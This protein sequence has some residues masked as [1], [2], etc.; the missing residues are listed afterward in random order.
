MN[1][2]ANETFKTPNYAMRRAVAL[3]A[4]ALAVFGGK[5]LYT[6]HQENA[7]IE[8]IERSGEDA[9]V[10]YNSG[11]FNEDKVTTVKIE[12]AQNAFNV[13]QQLADDNRDVRPLSDVITGQTG[14]YV[15]PGEVL[16]VPKSEL[17]K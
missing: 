15:D 3:G 11:H 5:A 16:V 7:V 17:E 8:N 13:A 2:T 14:N 1:L 4:V 10:H 12:H 6:G 9:L